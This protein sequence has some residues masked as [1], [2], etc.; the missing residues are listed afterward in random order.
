L[1]QSG[2]EYHTFNDE[3]MFLCDWHE[4][5]F[6]AMVV[7]FNGDGCIGR[8]KMQGGSLVDWRF[9]ATR[10]IISRKQTCDVS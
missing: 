4:E 10:T 7:F 9:S 1:G 2:I 5:T 3:I 8:R 6:G